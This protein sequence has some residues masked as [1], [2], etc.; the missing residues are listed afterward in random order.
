ML[1]GFPILTKEPQELAS[2]AREALSNFNIAEAGGLEPETCLKDLDY[3]QKFA[4]AHYRL[5]SGLSSLETIYLEEKAIQIQTKPI[6]AYLSIP[7]WLPFFRVA[8]LL[9][10][11]NIIHDFLQAGEMLFTKDLSTPRNFLSFEFYKEIFKNNFTEALEKLKVLLEIKPEKTNITFYEALQLPELLIWKAILSKE[12]NLY[13]I[14]LEDALIKHKSF[15][16][17][18]D[19]IAGNHGWVSLPLAHVCSFAYDQGFILPIKTDY[20]PS[21]LIRGE[22]I[23]G[24]I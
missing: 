13:S 19:S 17:Q 12:I 14:A 6:K 11:K 24:T 10:S 8:C 21:W 1:I 23:T 7:H 4:I 3:S 16:T 20:L 22:N 5:A 9:R 2:Y 18:P 15:W